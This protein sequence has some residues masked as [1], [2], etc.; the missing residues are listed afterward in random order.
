VRKWTVGSGN[1]PDDIDEL[2]D[3]VVCLSACKQRVAITCVGRTNTT[4]SLFDIPT[5]QSLGLITRSSLPLREARLSLDGEWV[6]ICGDD[7]CVKLIN[8]E[9]ILKVIEVSHPQP[10]KHVS[11]HPSGTM[12]VLA[13]ADR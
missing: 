5:N 7:S 12:L 11:Y 8:S 3:P 6:A 1:R 10:V 2:T 4:A 9:D 13:W